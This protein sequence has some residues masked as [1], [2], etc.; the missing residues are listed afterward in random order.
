MRLAKII[1][2]DLLGWHNGKGD[3]HIADKEVGGNIH[4]ICSRCRKGVM[5]DSQ[6]NWF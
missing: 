1:L 5:R 6:G 2:C 4:S 3:R